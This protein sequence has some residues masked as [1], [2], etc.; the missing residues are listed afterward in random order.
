MEE[1]GL[2]RGATRSSHR[3]KYVAARMAQ[4]AADFDVKA[5][6]YDRW[7]FENLMKLL[8]EEGIQR[9]LVGGR[10]SLTLP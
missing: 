6:A 1:R 9:N 2:Y 4:I 3:R 7:R 8:S 5:I 10:V